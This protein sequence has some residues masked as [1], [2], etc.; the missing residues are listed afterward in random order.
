[1]WH[2][3]IFPSEK[4]NIFLVCQARHTA[5]GTRSNQILSQELRSRVYL[6]SRDETKTRRFPL[7]FCAVI[8][9]SK[10]DLWANSLCVCTKS[11]DTAEINV[12]RSVLSPFSVQGFIAWFQEW[13]VCV[14]LPIGS[15]SAIFSYIDSRMLQKKHY[16]P[17]GH[18]SEAFRV[19]SC[20]RHTYLHFNIW[21]LNVIRFW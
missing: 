19:T 1:M 13:P 7:I 20:H 5:G 6:Q 11:Y 21:N 2:V 8:L 14:W 16:K 9:C 12:H 17:L 10:P 4:A 15:I 18:L 3:D